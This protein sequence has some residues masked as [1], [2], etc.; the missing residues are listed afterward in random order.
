MPRNLQCILD[1]K[2][3]VEEEVG[4]I[5]EEEHQTPGAT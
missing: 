2:H 1:L 3:K 4:K 5:L